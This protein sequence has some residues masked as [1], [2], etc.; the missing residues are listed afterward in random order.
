MAFIQEYY[1]GQLC[2]S[3]YCIRMA[4]RNVIQET[5][6]DILQFFFYEASGRRIV[7]VNGITNIFAFTKNAELSLSNNDKTNPI[8]LYLLLSGS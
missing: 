1:K 8:F 5:V 2:E 4:F 6:H 3:H 7:L